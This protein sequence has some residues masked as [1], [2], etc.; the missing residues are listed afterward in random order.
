MGLP[1]SRT[2]AEIEATARKA[3]RGHGCPWGLAEEAGKAARWLASNGL[4]GEV[5]MAKLLSNGSKCCCAGGG[6]PC[7]LKQATAF[8]DTASTLTAPT[9]FASEHP[10]LV[11]AQ[12]GRA[13]DSLGNGLTLE[14]DAAIAHIAPASLSMEASADIL[15]PTDTVTCHPT[16]KTQHNPPS[17]AACVVDPASWA[18]LDSLA[19]RI[20]VPSSDASRAGAG[21]GTSDND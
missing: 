19:Q 5:V 6:H 12:M 11:V 14:W 1:L 2:L 17:P 4:P 16:P 8:A 9:S 3:A 15:A 21:A 13:M 7:A 10:L 18:V 20:L